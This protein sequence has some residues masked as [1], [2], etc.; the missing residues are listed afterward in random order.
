MQLENILR[1]QMDA[2]IAMSSGYLLAK[3]M[4][5]SGF[6]IMLQ[7]FRIRKVFYFMYLLKPAHV[8][9]FTNIGK[10]AI[11]IFKQFTGGEI[12]IYMLFKSH[13]LANDPAVQFKTG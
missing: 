5:G 12:K 11:R 3:G 1:H 2:V 4:F 9:L 13:D 6:Y 7:L 8:R 10:Q